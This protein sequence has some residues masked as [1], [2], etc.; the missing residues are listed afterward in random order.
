MQDKVIV[1]VGATGGIGAALSQKLAAMGANLVLAARNI[2]RLSNL[3]AQLP[4]SVLTVPTDI[5]DPTQV[6]A[7]M[8]KSIEQYGKIDI[9]VN[10]AG[11]GIL[12]QFQQARA[13]RS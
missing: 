12:K 9:L 8:Q 11:A 6:E 10:A 3:A 13:K 1:I 4:N 2:D 7:L 5:T